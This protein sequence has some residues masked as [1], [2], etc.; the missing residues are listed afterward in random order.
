MA[1]QI[2]E[3]Q[4]DS[5]YYSNFK[6]LYKTCGWPNKFNPILFD[7][8][9][10]EGGKK[11]SYW[12]S[13]PERTEEQKSWAALDHLYVPIMANAREIVQQQIHLVDATYKLEHKM[14]TDKWE[15]QKLEGQRM[16]T[17]RTLDPMKTW[18]ED[19]A[20][21][22]TELDFKT[23]DLEALR[24]RTGRYAGPGWAG[25]SDAEIHK[26]YDEAAADK[27]I[28]TI[29]ALLGDKNADERAER[30]FR[31]AKQAARETPEEVWD[32]LAEA[33]KEFENDDWKDRW[34]IL[35]SATIVV[36]LRT[37]VD[38]DLSWQELQRRIVFELEKNEDR[39][40][41]GTRL[42][43]NDRGRVAEVLTH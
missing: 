30:V 32:A 19:Q 41:R 24:T 37:V 4:D 43:R 31:E 10:R 15:Q 27:R 20:N 34:S 38:Q 21:L 9:L 35:G 39:S 3:D 1:Q 23:S 18:D 25:V 5:D 40:W 33:N 22:R 14:Y 26:L 36:D 42:W 2:F 8:L 17:E 12:E 11:Y 6:E 29:R 16:N 7:R 13:S 28:A